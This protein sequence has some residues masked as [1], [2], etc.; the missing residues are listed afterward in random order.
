M[1]RWLVALAAGIQSPT[2]TAETCQDPPRIPREVI[3]EA[4]QAHGPYSLTSTTTS[5]L[6]GS[7]AL[8]AIVHRRQREAPGETQF[9]ISHADWFAAHLATA[10]VRYAE[11]SESA[12]AGYEYRQDVLVDYGPHV[13][14]EVEEGPVPR[15][16]LDVT[17][18]SA[19]PD[20]PAEFGYKDTL[21]VPKVDVFNGRVV[22]FKMLEYDSML[23]FD[24]V[25]GISVRPVGFLSA[26]FAVLGKPDLRQ[27]R[28]AVSKD[29]WQ[30]VRGQVNVLL[31]ISKTGTAT[32]EP[33]GRGHEGVPRN[34]ADL[35]A[36]RRYLAQPIE[37]RYGQPS[38]QTRQL[39]RRYA[40]V[41]CHRAMGGVGT[42]VE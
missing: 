31:G 29:Y 30:V 38:C 37:L 4:M 39:V 34:R 1:K 12:R 32:I 11:M 22:R 9:T 27:T 13:V 42:C 33:G 21:S 7:R 19:D 17:I 14:E 10:G 16:A 26:V 5:M 40:G 2:P 25:T 18:F 35:T 23:V 36:L 20:G 28:L 8:L 41:N 6:F 15:T 3:A 24:Q